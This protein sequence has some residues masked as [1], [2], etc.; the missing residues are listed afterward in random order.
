MNYTETYNKVYS[1]L[2][3]T[4]LPH[5]R[6]HNASLRITDALNYIYSYTHRQFPDMMEDVMA[7]VNDF[8]SSNKIG[9][10]DLDDK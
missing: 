6:L 3:K 8:A 4:N 1:A 5:E 9:G 10:Y 7:V 2:S